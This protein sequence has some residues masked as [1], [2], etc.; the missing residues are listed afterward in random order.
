MNGFL[1][2]FQAGTIYSRLGNR[3]EKSL[4]ED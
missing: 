1:S 3:E 2:D 4:S